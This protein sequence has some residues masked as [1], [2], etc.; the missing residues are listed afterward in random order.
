MSKV[1]LGYIGAI[2]KRE[3]SHQNKKEGNTVM[4]KK[5]DFVKVAKKMT[6]KVNKKSRFVSMSTLFFDN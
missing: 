3:P 4:L 2:K 6:I 5:V 1:R